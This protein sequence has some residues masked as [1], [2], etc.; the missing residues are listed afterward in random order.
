MS[1]EPKGPPDPITPTQEG[2]AKA[3]EL[4]LSYVAAGFTASQAL[5]LVAQLLRQLAANAAGNPPQQ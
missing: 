3:H 4:F 5:Y 1:D 2:A